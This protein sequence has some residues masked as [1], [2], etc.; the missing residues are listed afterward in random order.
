MTSSI[1]PTRTVLRKPSK[2]D[3][4]AIWSLIKRCKPLDENSMYCN[5]LQCD[6]FSDTCIV[7]EID[8]V[9]SAWVSG[10]VPPTEPDCLFVWQVAVSPEARGR[11]MGGKM[12]KALLNEVTRSS[13]SGEISRLKTTITRSN[14]AS[15]ALFEGF[16]KQTGGN[17][18][19]EAYFK[20]ED[21][22]DGA[23]PTEHMVTITFKEALRLAS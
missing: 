11:G 20:Q 1:T 18:S 5:L 16:A 23:A 13:D 8:G 9:I 22:F 12:L 4:A 19:S 15:W 14:D 6:H 21:H 2:E 17:L 3:G 7:A 10:Y